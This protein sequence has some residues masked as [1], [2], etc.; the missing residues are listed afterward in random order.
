MRAAFPSAPDEADTEVAEDGTACHWLAKEAW[1]GNSPREGSLSPNQRVI[2]EEMYDAV[3][4]YHD[5]LR[6][7]P[8]VDPM[9]EISIAINRILRG[10]R[11]TPDAWAYNPTLKRLYIADLK[12]GFK[13]VEVFE[14]LQEIC[15]AAGLIELLQLTDPSIT[16]EFVIVQ[17]RSP[18]KSGPVRKWITTL[19]EIEQYI[20]LLSAAAHRAINQPPMYVPN[21]G[22]TDC[23]GRHACVALQNAALTAVEISYGGTHHEL[24][25]DQLGSELRYLELAQKRLE[26][27]I[28]GLQSQAESLIRSGKFVKHYGLEPS[29]A[30]ERIREDLIDAFLAMENYFPNVNLRRPVKPITPNQARKLL[31]AIVVDAFAI[32]PST[33]VR[34]KQLDPKEA[35]KAFQSKQR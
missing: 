1:E 32:K 20:D 7:W 4:V 25:P 17:P 11:G 34:L 12:F 9:L 26:A 18:H 31:P 19:G 8:N 33:G 21:P 14:N 28:T 22:C 5:V 30:R 24:D 15:Y 3:D 35:R 13:F 10:M 23:P 2:T 29:Y 6:S 16:I 27:R